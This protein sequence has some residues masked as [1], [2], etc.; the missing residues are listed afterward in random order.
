MATHRHRH[1]RRRPDVS[2]R[3]TVLVAA[4]ILVGVDGAQQLPTDL[5]ASTTTSI[6]FNGL[7][8]TGTIP[9]EFGLLT[10]VTSFNAYENTLTGPIPSEIGRMGA[11]KAAFKVYK[12]SLSGTIP[13]EFGGMTELVGCGL[14]T[15]FLT[16]HL[17][18]GE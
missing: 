18:T 5:D 8:Y 2:L 16:G 17:P 10:G 6:A 1:R 12:N 15:N 9:T 13:T 14:Y 7:A 11:V 4:A 3:R